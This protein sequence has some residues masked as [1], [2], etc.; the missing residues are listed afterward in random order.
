MLILLLFA[1][2]AG[3]ITIAAPC[4]WPL[5]PIILS[6]SAVG[7]KKRPFG[8]VLGIA[9]SFTLFTI[10]LSLIIR[11][12]PFDPDSLRVFAT[13]VIAILGLSLLV[14][15]FGAR[16]EVLVSKLS[17]RFGSR[18]GERREGLWGGFITGFALGTLWSPCAGPVLAAIATLAATQA[19]S[20]ELV[21]VTSAFAAGVAV[22]LFLFALLGQKLLFANQALRSHIGRIQQGFGV[23]MILAAMAIYTGYDR[24][25]QAK[26][27]DAFP[28]YGSFFQGLEDNKAVE[29]ALEDF[30]GSQNAREKSSQ[31]TQE[32]D[33]S[34]I[35]KAPE[36]VG[37]SNWIQTENGAPLRM[38][39]LRGKVV[40][41]DFWTYSCINCIRTLPY[42]TGWYEKYKNDGFVVVGVHTPEF[43][44]ERKTEN[45]KEAIARYGITY[46][47]AQDNGYETWNAYDN[48]Y[49]PAHYLID[50]NGNIRHTHF[51][52]GNYEETEKNIQDL[53]AEAGRGVQEKPLLDIEEKSSNRGRTPETYLGL[54]RIARFVSPERVA[55]GKQRYTIPASLK[56]HTFAY[57]GDWSLDGERAMSGEGA[58]LDLQFVGKKVFLV[59]APP[60][61]GMATVRVSLDG[62]LIADGS[63]ADV[64]S[65]EV[66]VDADRLYELVNLGDDGGEHRLRLEFDQPGIG[67]YAF[68]FE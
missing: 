15:A 16:L 6:S 2:V 33:S 68:T 28:E 56:K 9:L 3:L 20:L 1:F 32:V 52:E 22:P 7:G 13:I 48:R 27:Y 65:G 5:L 12:I 37:I 23:I 41:V 36:F 39:D 42:V 61:K 10:F 25:L 57:G 58:S 4:I 11:V 14:P 53:L 62:A 55:L 54:D 50:A 47:V 51:G 17:G 59:M 29:K 34:I 46:P 60:E 8:I 19:I 26:I 30:Q 67:A 38:E 44:F 66:A 63:G 64:R 35:G 40:L 45:V 43:V 21:F 31:D 24:T 49:W 18:S